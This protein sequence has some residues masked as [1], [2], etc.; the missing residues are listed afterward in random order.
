MEL[1]FEIDK[2]DYDPDGEVKGVKNGTG[3]A[4]SF[5]N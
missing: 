1:L 2:K 5:G 3:E 4:A